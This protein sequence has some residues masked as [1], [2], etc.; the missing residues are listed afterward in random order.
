M[1]DLFG[2]YSVNLTSEI[3]LKLNKF[4]EMLLKKNEVTNLTSI[5][6]DRELWIKH[7]LDSLIGERFIE[8]GADCCDVGAGGGFPSIPLAIYR[9]DITFTL[10]EATGK[11]CD[12]LREVKAGLPLYNIDVVN[13]RAEEIGKGELRE[14]FD[15]VTARAVARLNTLCEYCM[16][17]VKVGGRFIAYKGKDAAETGEAGNAVRI[18]GGEIERVESVSLPDGFGE[19]NIIVIKKTR[20]TPSAY[21]RGRGKE[22][23]DPL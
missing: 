11:K 2:K 6:G 23:K 20:K 14:R 15:A 5:S 9:D 22:R 8:R 4:G 13:A 10:V 17:L 21:P 7:F 3:A 12:F 19:R 16:P 1:V 18:L